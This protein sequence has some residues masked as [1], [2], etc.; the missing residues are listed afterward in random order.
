[1]TQNRKSPLQTISNKFALVSVT[2]DHPF[3]KEIV[4]SLEP[5]LFCI[6]RID[7]GNINLFMMN[8]RPI[9]LFT[10]L[11]HDIVNRSCSIMF[12]LSTAAL[13]KRL[14]YNLLYAGLEKCFCELN[15]NRVEAETL[16]IDN[17]SQTILSHFQ[18]IDEGI[19]YSS[20][21]RNKTFYDVI[22]Y[23]MLK[24]EW[25]KV[26]SSLLSRRVFP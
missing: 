14:S 16:E 25:T 20:I 4:Y 17:T 13:H 24:H 18:F 10:I 5:V 11:N 9:G 3:V 19:K 1:M 22:M 12:A 2:S 15:V 8:N 26:R 23:S 6:K 7:S 21:R